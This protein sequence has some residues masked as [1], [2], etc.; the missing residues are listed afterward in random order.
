LGIATH[1]HHPANY[2]E[3]VRLNIPT[4]VCIREPYDAVLSW[5]ALEHQ[6]GTLRNISKNNIEDTFLR[7]CSYFCDFN[8][9]L[10]SLQAN[11]VILCPFEQSK[12]DINLIIRETNEVFI[13]DFK[14]ISEEIKKDALEDRVAYHVGPNK[15]REELK[16]ILNKICKPLKKSNSYIQA[17][18]CYE[19]VLK[20]FEKLNYA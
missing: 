20:K 18:R 11:S 7:Q 5:I 3:S 19:E 15:E 17:Y 13:K 12:E 4:I 10:I 2:L 6:N 16:Q 8:Q 1:L 14:M 9:P